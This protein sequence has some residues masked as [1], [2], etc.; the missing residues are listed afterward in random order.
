[1]EGRK[2]FIISF[3]SSSMRIAL[4]RSRVQGGDVLGDQRLEEQ[5]WPG[6]R[7]SALARAVADAAPSGET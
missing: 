3:S 5:D 4:T 7:Q 2:A 1:M 6:H